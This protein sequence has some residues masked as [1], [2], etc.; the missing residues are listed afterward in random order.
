MYDVVGLKNGNEVFRVTEENET[1]ARGVAGLKFEDHRKNKIDEIKVMLGETVVVSDSWKNFIPHEVTMRLSD[2]G[3]E[4]TR[5]NAISE[6]KYMIS[7]IEEGGS[8]YND[9][10][11][12]AKQL[13]KEA[14]KFIRDWK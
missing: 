6:A 5:E 7:V 3:D 1:F 9:Y 13:V 4:E 8:S 14:R 12:H 2:N 10:P 11:E